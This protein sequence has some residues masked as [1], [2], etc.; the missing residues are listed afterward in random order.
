MAKITG[1]SWARST[2]NFWAGCTKISPGCDGCYAEAFQR[3]IQGKDA[4]SGEAKNWGPGRPRLPYILGAIKDLRSWNRLA[5]AEADQGLSN[6]WRPEC[7]PGYWPVFINTQSDFFDNEAPQEWRDLAFPVF[8]QCSN[9]SILLVTKRIGN[10]R[11]MVPVRW[12]THGF[13]SNVRIM[14][15]VVNQ[16]E[17]DRDIP[18]LLTLRC[19]NGISY[20]PALGPID[21]EK[22]Q[23]GDI[24]GIPCYL[25]ALTGL[26]YSDATGGVS[27]DNA[28]RK[29][30]W[31][32]P[33]GESDQPGHPAR[34]FDMTWA[35]NAVK[36]GKAA[37]VPVHVKQMGSTPFDINISGQ[38][39]GLHLKARDGD[40]PSEWP[41]DLRVQ[42]FPA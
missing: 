7:K 13:P 8:E 18:K 22:I 30:D 11:D 20:E 40:D 6:A 16:L 5:E 2:R 3:W 27:F 34:F 4:E 37:G 21:F 31:I 29:I 1:I 38:P 23:C 39:R 12:F 42:E 10:V 32:I 33:G 19:K 9:L 28:P 17:A 26:I 35:R 24:A 14:I 25:D 15:T 36:Q 41:E